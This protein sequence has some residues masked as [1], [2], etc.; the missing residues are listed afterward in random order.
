L[1]KNNIVQRVKDAIIEMLPSGGVP[2]DKVAKKLNMSTRSLQRK[3]Q[4]VHTTF[5]KLLD[6][7]RR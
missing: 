3:L 2:D 1:D 4:G 5:G 7:E 6:E